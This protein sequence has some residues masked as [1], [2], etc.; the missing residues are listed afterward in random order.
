MKIYVDEQRAYLNKD[1]TG[2]TL[3]PRRAGEFTALQVRVW[4]DRA[5]RNM[6]WVKP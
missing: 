5:R 1:A 6:C 4:L 3:N 2:W